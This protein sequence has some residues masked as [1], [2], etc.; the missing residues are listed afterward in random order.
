MSFRLRL[1]IPLVI[2]CFSSPFGS[3]ASFLW[4]S[5]QNISCTLPLLTIAWLLSNVIILEL[6]QKSSRGRGAF[7]DFSV[8]SLGRLAYWGC[9]LHKCFR[10]SFTG[11]IIFSLPRLWLQLQ[12]NFLEA[13][14]S[15]QDNSSPLRSPRRAG[16]AGGKEL[17]HLNSALAKRFFVKNTGS[18][19]VQEKPLIYNVSIC[20][21]L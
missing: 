5:F 17:H 20:F 3:R 9:G 10:L 6:P 21:L 1:K 18:Q 14:S 15:T 7:C 13:W 8:K 4:Y 19:R 2:L 11:I 12:V 16:G